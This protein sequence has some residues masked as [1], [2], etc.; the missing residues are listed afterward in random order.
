MFLGEGDEVGWVEE[1]LF[2]LCM[3]LLKA[4]FMLKS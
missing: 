1:C 3:A 4:L 2:K